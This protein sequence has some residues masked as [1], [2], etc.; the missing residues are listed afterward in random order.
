MFSDN[1][2]YGH[3]KILLKY[4][5]IKKDLPLYGIL[6]HGYMVSYKL[7]IRFKAN[8]YFPR[9]PYFA[10]NNFLARNKKINSIPIGSPF[11]YLHHLNKKK[12]F[13]P[14]GTLLFPSHSNPEFPQPVDHL[15][16]I[17][18][19]K[20]NFVGPY[21]VSLFYVDRLNSKTV[22]IYKKYKFEILCSG[23]R[24]NNNFLHNVYRNIS[25]S[26][27]VCFTEFGTP[28]LYSMFLKK[29]I[30]VFESDNNK[31]FYTYTGKDMSFFRSKN[32]NLFDRKLHSKSDLENNFKFSKKELGFQYIKKK[33]DLIN[34]LKLNNFFTVTLSTIV[35]FLIDLKYGKQARTGELNK[36]F[37]RKM[38]SNNSN[39]LPLSELH[40]KK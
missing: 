34:I 31:N 13:N 35:R 7:Q 33:D 14:K 25:N 36:N 23:N 22:K 18:F 11:I 39:K 8:K 27:F 37:T 30:A 9:A 17:K 16:L 1:D 2:W 28:T 3:K 6:Q 26:E 15:S 38:P 29:K 32:P 5:N 4:C 40:Y 24:G 19:I 10:W 21:K 12:K 20:K